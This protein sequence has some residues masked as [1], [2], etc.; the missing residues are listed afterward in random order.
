MQTCGCR[1]GLPKLVTVSETLLA[2]ETAGIVQAPLITFSRY[3]EPLSARNNS[4]EDDTSSKESYYEEL[5]T[6]DHIPEQVHTVKKIT[7]KGY[8]CQDVG[9]RKA[10]AVSDR[11]GINL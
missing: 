4:V 7:C 3:S 2:A 6:M 5:M 8:P 9:R 10:S 1:C 11:L